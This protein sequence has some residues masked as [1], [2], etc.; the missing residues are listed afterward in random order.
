MNSMNPKRNVTLSSSGRETTSLCIFRPKGHWKRSATRWSD[1]AALDVVASEGD[2][3]TLIKKCVNTHTRRHFHY[4]CRWSNLRTIEKCEDMRTQPLFLFTEKE[5][6]FHTQPSGSQS[7]RPDSRSINQTRLTRAS[8]RWPVCVCVQVV[9]VQSVHTHRSIFCCPII[10]STHTCPFDYTDHWSVGRTA[11]VPN[12]F[13]IEKTLFYI[14][15]VLYPKFGMGRG[16]C[17]VEFVIN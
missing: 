1:V 3:Q 6:S 9:A 8:T 13:I 7:T 11:F 4:D 2:H 15:R 16:G 12:D 17:E 5:F 10:A 14:E